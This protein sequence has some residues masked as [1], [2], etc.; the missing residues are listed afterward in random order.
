MLLGLENRKK[1]EDDRWR[2]KIDGQTG[3]SLLYSGSKHTFHFS[4]SQ[5][6]AIYLE[7]LLVLQLNQVFYNGNMGESPRNEVL[8]IKNKKKHMKHESILFLHLF[9]GFKINI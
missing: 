1:D 6:Q 9:F 7:I 8:M 2:D 4:N 3:Q 5:N